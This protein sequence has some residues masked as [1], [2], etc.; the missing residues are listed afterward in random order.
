MDDV[1]NND[2]KRYN[3][4][5]PPYIRGKDESDTTVDRSDF[6]RRRPPALG[7]FI[8]DTLQRK[9]IA[10]QRKVLAAYKDLCDEQEESQD[11]DLKGPYER[12]TELLKD[13]ENVTRMS[14]LSKELVILRE[15]IQRMFERYKDE[16][17]ALDSRNRASRSTGGGISRRA[18]CQNLVTEFWGSLSGSKLRCSK[19]LLKPEEYMA[20]YAY[21]LSVS[22]E[23]NRNSLYGKDF[24]FLFAHSELCAIKAGAAKYGKVTVMQD[25]AEFLTLNG[26]LLKSSI[27]AAG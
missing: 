26:P 2:Q 24:A 13:P 21:F 20:S 18:L 23:Y 12:I 22:S 3:N 11:S 1:Y 15:H 8:L 14:F 7:P 10:L 9:G 27:K 19:A 17:S 6:A 4:P 16:V 5:Q 25:S